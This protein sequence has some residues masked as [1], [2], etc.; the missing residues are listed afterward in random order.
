MHIPSRFGSLAG[1]NQRTGVGRVMNRMLVDRRCFVSAA[2][3]LLAGTQARHVGAQGKPEKTRVSIAVA[4]KASLDCLALTI[5]DSLGYF[6]AEG[7]EVEI[8]DFGGGARALQAVVDGSGDVVGGAFEHTINLQG[9]NQ[10]F[11]AF[12]LLGRAPQ[13]ALGVCTRTMPA[14]KTVPDLKGRKIGVALPGSVADTVANLVLMRG[15]VLPRE[16]SFVEMPSVSAAL[17]AVRSGQLDAISYTEPLMT[18][19][20]HKADVRIISDTRTL[21]GTQEVFGG[22]MPGACLYAPGDFVQKNPGTVQ[23]LANAAVH[24]LKWLQTAGPSDLIKTVPEAYLH[25]DR[26][27]YLASFNKSREAIAVDGLIPDEGVRTALRAMGRL[28]TSIKTDKID[29]ARTFTNEFARKA[30][31]KFRA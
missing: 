10:F 6:A 2:A 7:L 30:K 17:A 16:V 1:Q 15:G 18:M 26:S 23:A 9:K 25:G 14:Y 20:E 24:A 11:R 8:H 4:A 13:V 3:L 27:L 28:D 12:V 31:D 21:K 5:A 29:L 22:S 19:L